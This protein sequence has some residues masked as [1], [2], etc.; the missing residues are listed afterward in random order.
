MD[1]RIHQSKSDLRRFLVNAHAIC[2]RVFP[3]VDHS[4]KDAYQLCCIWAAEAGNITP[5]RVNALH[6][7]TPCS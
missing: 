5:M 7:Q 1:I 2:N 3:K 6:V 4:G